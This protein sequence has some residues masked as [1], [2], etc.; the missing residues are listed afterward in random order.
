[1]DQYSEHWHNLS[2]EGHLYAGVSWDQVYMTPLNNIIPWLTTSKNNSVN[3][4][5]NEN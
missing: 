1:M 4:K 3:F 2:F 5:S